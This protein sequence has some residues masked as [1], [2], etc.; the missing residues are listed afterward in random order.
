MKNLEQEK[1]EKLYNVKECSEAFGLNKQT[2][3]RMIK[4]GEISGVQLA[5][6]WKVPQS[7]MD[8]IK[9]LCD[10]PK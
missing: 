7:E 10:E 4:R 9:E 3:I 6:K 5:G 8:R 2:V 1:L